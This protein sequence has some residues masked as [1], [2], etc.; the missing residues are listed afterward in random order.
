MVV[1]LLD[2]VDTII[3]DQNSPTVDIDRMKIQ[4]G[5]SRD[6]VMRKIHVEGTHFIA[7]CIGQRKFVHSLPIKQGLGGPTPYNACVLFFFKLEEAVSYYIGPLV[8]SHLPEMT[9][10]ISASTSLAGGPI[11]AAV[12]VP[13]INFT[14]NWLAWYVVLIGIYC[15]S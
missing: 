10:S 5:C 4:F 2:N 8:E 14:R 3:V 15:L 9:T 1:E 6:P 13:E 7:R 12:A 11:K